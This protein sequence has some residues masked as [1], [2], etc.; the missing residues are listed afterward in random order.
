MVLIFSRK[1]EDPASPEGIMA[2][3]AEAAHM[4]NFFFDKKKNNSVLLQSNANSSNNRLL[5][6]LLYRYLTERNW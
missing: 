6:S 1:V 3:A 4:V 2:K 5:T